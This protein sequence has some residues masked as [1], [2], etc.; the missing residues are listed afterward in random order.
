MAMVL[1]CLVRDP[2]DLLEMNFTMKCDGTPTSVFRLFPKHI[3]AQPLQP[4]GALGI[5]CIKS[6]YIFSPAKL[7]D[8]QHV[9]QQQ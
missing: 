5:H 1:C 9:Q 8:V 6:K 2:N 4:N 3:Y 7:Y